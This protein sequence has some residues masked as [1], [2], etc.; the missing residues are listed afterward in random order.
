MRQMSLDSSGV[1]VK[2]FTSEEMFFMIESMDKKGVDLFRWALEYNMV[3]DEGDL[4]FFNTNILSWAWAFGD[5]CSL[6][7]ATQRVGER[8]ANIVENWTI[9]TCKIISFSKIPLL[10]MNAAMFDWLFPPGYQL[11]NMWPISFVKAGRVDLAYHL[12]QNREEDLSPLTPDHWDELLKVLP[13]KRNSP[14]HSSV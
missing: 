3:D 9:E 11:S 12:F 8:S 6:Y 1:P 4:E 10:H 7:L 14:L 5:H 13:K 2:K